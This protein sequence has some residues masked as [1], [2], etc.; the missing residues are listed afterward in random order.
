MD[1]LTKDGILKNLQHTSRREVADD[2]WAYPILSRS[3]EGIGDPT[4][5][6]NTRRRD[7]FKLEIEVTV[8]S[9]PE[10]Y[11]EKLVAED[12][13][14]HIHNELYLPIIRELARIRSKAKFEDRKSVVE[15]L[16]D[17]MNKFL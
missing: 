17:L 10:T 4:Y 6:W 16:T 2:G 11:N 15:A 1:I 12:C 14:R 3:I 8:E 9:R 13:A 5:Q 7:T